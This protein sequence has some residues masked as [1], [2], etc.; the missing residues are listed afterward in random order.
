[1]HQ[2]GFG[3][4]EDTLCQRKQFLYQMLGRLRKHHIA[5]LESYGLVKDFTDPAPALRGLPIKQ[6]IIDQY[7]RDDRLEDLY[8]LT[9]TIAN[10]SFLEQLDRDHRQLALS[11][12]RLLEQV[13]QRVLHDL[14]RR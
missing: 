11:S 8:P 1:M 2:R 14:V 7:R 4:D 6:Q 12:R 3:L 5:L 10:S 9:I 13:I